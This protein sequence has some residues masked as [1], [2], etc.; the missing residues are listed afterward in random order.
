MSVDNCLRLLL[1]LLQL[2][3][4][5]HK[6]KSLFLL[7]SFSAGFSF[8]FLLLLPSELFVEWFYNGWLLF[9]YELGAIFLEFV[10]ESWCACFDSHQIFKGKFVLNFDNDVKL[11]TQLSQRFLCF[12]AFFRYLSHLVFLK[13][14]DLLN[15]IWRFFLKF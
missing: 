10:K 7:Q 3:V 12:F 4:V 9:F 11:F 14:F 6:F 5:F 8:G 13:L 1:Y 15:G 2:S